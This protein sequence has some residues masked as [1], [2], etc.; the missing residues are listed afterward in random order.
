MV[1]EE[2][3]K[4][5][6]NRFKKPF[7]PVRLKPAPSRGKSLQDSIGGFNAAG[8]FLRLYGQLSPVFTKSYI[9]SEKI[10]TCGI[11][12]NGGDKMEEMFIDRRLFQRI[13]ADFT[14]WYSL[15][16]RKGVE[17]DFLGLDFSG[18]GIRVDSVKEIPY[19]R[20]LDVSINSDALK[21][22]LKESAQVIWQKEL[23]PGK[24]QAGLK[25]FQPRLAAFWPILEAQKEAF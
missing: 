22:S 25:F 24:W 10:E 12:K 5:I 13:N 23:L 16:G 4:T 20:I 9:F 14:G 18:S 6:S 19:D 17:G 3:G 21:S 8:D 2:P 1:L 15:K 11:I 7:L